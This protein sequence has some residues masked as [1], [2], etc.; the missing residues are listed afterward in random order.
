VIELPEL[1]PI[2]AITEEIAVMAFLSGHAGRPTIAG[3]PG[4]SSPDDEGF[5]VG[6]RSL[7]SKGLVQVTEEGTSVARLVTDLGRCLADP[8]STGLLLF[9]SEGDGEA[10]AYAS[11]GDDVLLLLQHVS[12]GVLTCLI[13]P[14]QLHAVT[15]AVAANLSADGREVSVRIAP[16]DGEPVELGCTDGRWVQLHDE[17]RTLDEDEVRRLISTLSPGDV[18]AGGSRP[19]RAE[20]DE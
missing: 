14:T 3:V 4:F 12:D 17:A 19:P 7:L 11:A 18:A 9:A 6:M 20:T 13:G 8:D 5:D 10:F 1:F 15:V 2:G 16:L